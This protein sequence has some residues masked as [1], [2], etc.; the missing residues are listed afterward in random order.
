MLLFA[1]SYYS[2]V[3]DKAKLPPPKVVPSV[4]DSI[5]IKYAADV[6]PIMHTNCAISSSC[7]GGSTVNGNFFTYDGLKPSAANGK[8]RERVIEKKDMPPGGLPDSLIQII[9][10]WLKD[11]YPNN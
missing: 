6:E 5:S 2:C 8:V 9:D 7:H 3:K 4:C 10:C 11:G 1:V